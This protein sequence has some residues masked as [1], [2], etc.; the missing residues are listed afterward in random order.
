M[1]FDPEISEWDNPPGF[2]PVSGLKSGGKRGELKHLSTRRKR[3]QNVIPPVVASERGRAQTRAVARPDGGCRDATSYGNCERN[4][5]DSRAIAGDSPLRE[6]ESG[7]AL[8]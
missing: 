2:R 1:T 7:V 5:P 8:P 6:A 3:K 4:R